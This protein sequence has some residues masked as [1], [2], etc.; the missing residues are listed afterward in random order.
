MRERGFRGTRTRRTVIV[1]PLLKSLSTIWFGYLTPNRGERSLLHTLWSVRPI[2]GMKAIAIWLIE[3]EAQVMV[4][5]IENGYC[6]H[7]LVTKIGYQYYGLWNMYVA[8]QFS[9][10]TQRWSITL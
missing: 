6:D 7:Y 2:Q 9:A 5:T 8:L 3:V 10:L 4:T 1:S